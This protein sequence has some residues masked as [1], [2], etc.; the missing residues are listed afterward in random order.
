MHSGKITD[1]L[2]FQCISQQTGTTEIFF[3]CGLK[4]FF[5]LILATWFSNYLFNTSSCQGKR[6]KKKFV[7]N[8]HEINSFNQ[9]NC[10]HNMHCNQ[11]RNST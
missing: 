8:Q 11:L 5:R 6:L 7:A 3:S 2:L 1:T 9:L 4:Q 10:G